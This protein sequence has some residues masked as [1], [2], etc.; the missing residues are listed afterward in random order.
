MISCVWSQQYL[1]PSRNN[2]KETIFTN[3]VQSIAYAYSNL[4]LALGC[5]FFND[6]VILPCQLSQQSKGTLAFRVE[7][8]NDKWWVGEYFYIII[9]YFIKY[10]MKIISILVSSKAA[11]NSSQKPARQICQSCFFPELTFAQT[12]NYGDNRQKNICLASIAIDN[13]FNIKLHLAQWTVF[14]WERISNHPSFLTIV[15]I[16]NQENT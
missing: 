15:N 2:V 7:N 8:Q 1:L 11:N 9:K 3:N 12:P 6:F 14:F 4:S 13:T 5:S 16:D 10:F